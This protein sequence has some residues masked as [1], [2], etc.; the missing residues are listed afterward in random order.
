MDLAW[1]LTPLP[2]FRRSTR[3][4]RLVPLPAAIHS[5]DETGKP[6]ARISP[7]AILTGNVSLRMHAGYAETHHLIKVHDWG[8]SANGNNRPSS[9]RQEEIKLAHQ[10]YSTCSVWIYLFQLR[11]VL[12]EILKPGRCCCAIRIILYFFM[13]WKATEV[14]NNGDIST[15]E[16]GI[17]RGKQSKIIEAEWRIYASVI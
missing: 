11:Q 13:L 2:Q 17:C 8:T 14:K 10:K 1:N 5:S 4:S 16:P 9:R 6:Y 12:P 3:T 7:V 15:I